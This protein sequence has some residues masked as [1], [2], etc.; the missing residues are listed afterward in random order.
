MRALR[1]LGCEVAE[2]DSGERPLELV[3]G[4]RPDVVCL[5]LWM[6]GMSG[7]DVLEELRRN[8]SDLPVVIVSA[9]PFS[10]TMR[11]AEVRGAAGYISK[12]FRLAQLGSVLDSVLRGKPSA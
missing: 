5:D 8:H 2:A 4:F 11:E 12:P 6:D 3:P 9:D 7:L 10:D 1:S